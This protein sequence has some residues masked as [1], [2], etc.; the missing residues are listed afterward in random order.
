[1]AKVDSVTVCNQHVWYESITRF[2]FGFQFFASLLLGD[3]IL[4]YG[5]GCLRRTGKSSGSY[6][7]QVLSLS[8]SAD[9]DKLSGSLAV[10]AEI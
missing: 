10:L 1:M 7:D 4:H 2:N 9:T 6:K 8:G 5:W 3:K